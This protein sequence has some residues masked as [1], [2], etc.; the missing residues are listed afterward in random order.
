MLVLRA[1]GKSPAC[2]PPGTATPPSPALLLPH[3][4]QK[5]T[6]AVQMEAASRTLNTTPAMT[7]RT[8]S[9]TGRFRS[10]SGSSAAD[11]AVCVCVLLYVYRRA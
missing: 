9:A 11:E 8:L 2:M 3:S 5:Q 6:W 7:T 1:P 10:R 4:H